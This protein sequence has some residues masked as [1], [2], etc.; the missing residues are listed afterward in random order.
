M[1]ESTEA[2]QPR[3]VSKPRINPILIVLPLIDVVAILLALALVTYEYLYMD[4]VY[5]GVSVFGTEL[6]GLTLAEA[7]I[8]LQQKFQ[9]YQPIKLT[10]RYGEQTWAVSPPELG[11]SLDARATAISAY[12]AGREGSTFKRLWDQSRILWSGHAAPFTLRIDEGIGIL[13]FSRLAQEINQP[14]RDAALVVHDLQ[15]EAVPSQVGREVDI[16]ATRQLIYQRIATLSGGIVDLVV[17]QTPPAIT[18]VSQ[19]KFDVEQ[20]LGSTLVLKL[21]GDGVGDEIAYT[22]DQTALAEMLTLRQVK[23]DNG[24]VILAAG[25]NQ[26]KLTAHLQELTKQIDQPPR[27]GRFD[28]DPATGTLIPIVTSQ[29]GRS[30]NITETVRLIN[31]QAVTDQR[32]VLLPVTITKPQVATENAESLG[33][34]ELVSEA[35]TYFKGSSSGRMHNIHVAA[36]RFHG[37]V[38]P[39]EG[40]FSFNEHLGEVSAATGYE[41]SIIIWGN[42][43]AVGIGGGVCQVS[44]TAFRAA[45]WGGYPVTERWAHGYRVGWYEPPVG[46]DATV[47]SPQVDFKF[48]NDTPHYLLIETE[49]DLKAGTVTFRFYGTKTGRTVEIEGPFEAN[50]VSHGPDVYRED[51]T[52]PEGTTEQIDWAHDGVDVTVYRMVREGDKVLW[53]DTFFSRYRPWQAVYLI[54][55]GEGS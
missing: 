18:D 23:R 39:P 53:K 9:E 40:I 22:L 36:S 1:I 11:V 24:Q 32:Q 6:G 15:V 16:A 17:H 37:L 8:V 54:G 46:M 34:K 2:V 20:M 30:L 45:F 3:K 12:A 43:S 19:A 14:V 41:E 33:I 42:R 38:I 55:T 21:P 52:L 7:E 49:T 10:L 28:F 26:V 44:T 29:E 51:P 47:Y 13:Y 48:V 31:A 25:L 27:D 4:R 35:T 50:V 5:P